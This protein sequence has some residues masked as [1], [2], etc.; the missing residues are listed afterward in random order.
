MTFFENSTRVKT[1]ASISLIALSFM[2]ITVATSFSQCAFAQEVGAEIKISA[3]VVSKLKEM[4]TE[5]QAKYTQQL[6]YDAGIKVNLSQSSVVTQFVPVSEDTFIMN[7]VS[8]NEKQQEVYKQLGGYEEQQKFILQLTQD[9][10]GKGFDVKGVDVKGDL[11]N[12]VTQIVPDVKG[13]DVKGDLG[14]EVTQIVPDVKG[15]DVKGDLGNE[16][17]QIVPDIKGVDAEIVKNPVIGQ[18]VSEVIVNVKPVVI[19]NP[20]VESEVIVNVKPVVIENPKVESEV[21]V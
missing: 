20:K 16:V 18:D 2:S 11:G 7:T 4:N 6:Y 8:L 12:E 21:I 3:D 10:S 9:F 1:A 15:I 17:T 13:V 14:N 5:E 19:E